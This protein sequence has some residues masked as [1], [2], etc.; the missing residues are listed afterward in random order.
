MQGL[1]VDFSN[2]K[3]QVSEEELNLMDFKI[4]EAH[5]KLNE[6]TGAG[7]DMLRLDGFSK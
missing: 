5:K 3:R 4:K 2:L 7:R 6:K 1:N